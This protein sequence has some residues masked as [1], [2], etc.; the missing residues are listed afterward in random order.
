MNY[1]HTGVPKITFTKSA[2]PFVLHC[3][4]RHFD[5]SS[6][7]YL[8]HIY[9]SK[10]KTNDKWYFIRASKTI[11]WY[12]SNPPN[13]FTRFSPLGP[14]WAKAAMSLPISL[15]PALVL[16]RHNTRKEVL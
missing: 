11:G 16:F 8:E 7:T 1:Y 4:R 5:D 12:H 2:I 3:Y 6:I 14:S 9:Q 15:R 10:E 13:N